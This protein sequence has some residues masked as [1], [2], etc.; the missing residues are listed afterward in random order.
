[1]LWRSGLVLLLWS[2]LLVSCGG[3]ESPEA[4]TPTL[5]AQMAQ[6]KQLF[7]QH[8]GTCHAIEAETVI[9]GPSLFAMSERVAERAPELTAEQYVE[10]SI[11]QPGAFVVPGYDNLM[12][13]NLS[14]RLDGQELDA[15]V[16]YVLN[17]H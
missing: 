2:C 13:A 14:K 4:P 3:N 17:L 16:T 8:C 11:L 6:G 1:M 7:S 10:L 12:P 9:V 5:T 15:I